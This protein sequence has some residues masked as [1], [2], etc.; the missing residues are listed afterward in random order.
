MVTK[1]LLC[2]GG[3]AVHV[4]TSRIGSLPDAQ[5]SILSLYP[6]E[7]ERLE[8]AVAAA[9]K[10][11]HCT[12]DSGAPPTH[13]KPAAI[14]DDPSKV[15]PDADVV[16]MALP[17]AF[18]QLY[19]ERLKP[20][21]KAGVII[22]AMPGQ[23]GLDLC[24]RHVLGK[25]FDS[26]DLFGFE[27]LPWACRIHEYGKSVEV[28]G[29]KAE[30]GATVV[31]CADDSKEEVLGTLQHLIGPKPV[32]K[33][34][35]NFLATTLANVNIVHP[36]ISYG[37]YRDRDLTKPFDSPPI[38]YQGVDERTGEMLERISDE[39]LRLRD[40][41][42]RKYPTLDLSSLIH[43]REFMVKCYSDYIDDTTNVT[44]MLQTS[45]A[46]VGLCHPM[47]EVNVDGTTKYLPDFNYRYFTEDLPAGMIVIRG[48][49]ELA[50]VP[51]PTLDEVIMWSQEVMGRE[52]LV[53]GKLVGKDL[54]WTRC[55]QVYGYSDLDTF[56]RANHY[57][58]GVESSDVSDLQ[59]AQ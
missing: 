36:T 44:S 17:A 42:C 26:V 29:T 10:G 43:L 23:S 33:S 11:V 57:L 55:P 3:N 52:F 6:G 54:K 38:F 22:G 56:L 24:A 32:L 37:F 40:F 34:L 7:A 12:T 5:A 59:I 2:G 15:A 31:T 4:L 1:V 39:V 8:K 46:H 19:L 13:G 28:L 25:T 49:A 41:L 35:G 48:I 18:H 20:F 21:L 53:D 27:T 16:V 51:T 58:E 47:I 30:I 14:S 45:R 50:G 9:G